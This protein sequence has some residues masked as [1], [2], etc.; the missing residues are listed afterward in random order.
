VR[1][2]IETRIEDPPANLPTHPAPR[3]AAI[4]KSNRVVGHAH[5]GPKLHDSKPTGVGFLESR[6]LN[7]SN[8]M[9]GDWP[10]EAEVIAPEP[11]IYQW[12]KDLFP[13]CRSLTGDGVRATLSYLQR[14]V[15]A[16][17]IHEV[18]S[19]TAAFDW[20]VPDEWNVS[21]AYIESELGRRVIDFAKNNLHLMGY[22]EP[23]DLWLDRKQLDAYLYSLPEHPDWIPYVT[24]YYE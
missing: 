12:L 8:Q 4:S 19:G 22:S 11:D 3:P 15:P 21:E 2:A 18:A 6:K 24:S 9:I 1:R 5:Q 16:L 7:P 20:T 10:E 13:I 17:Q 14:I 23:V